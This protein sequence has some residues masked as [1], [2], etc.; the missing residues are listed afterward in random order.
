MSY[1]V[2]KLVESN[3]EILRLWRN[4]ERN[5][6]YYEF[7][8][9]ISLRDQ[10]LWYTQLNESTNYWIFYFDEKPFGFG[11]LNLVNNVHGEVGL[12][13]G[14]ADYKGLG[15]VFYISNFLINYAFE[16]LN[17]ELLTAKVNS[18]H[19]EAI[20]YN[21]FLGFVFKRNK[22]EEFLFQELD[23]EGFERFK[24]KREAFQKII[25]E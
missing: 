11:H 9:E 13:I 2:E 20:R 6:F 15:F 25:F 14:D 10:Y 23:K 7:Q 16:E 21:E 1:R 18:K 24:I 17:L 5:V 19:I 3:L 22:N 12:M 4:D 8:Q